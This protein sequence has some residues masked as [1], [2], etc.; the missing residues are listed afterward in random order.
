MGVKLPGFLSIKRYQDSI[1]R[2]AN[3]DNVVSHVIWFDLVTIFVLIL[4]KASRW[5]L[6]S[7]NSLWVDTPSFLALL[8]LD[9]TLA[10][11]WPYFCDLPQ[12]RKKTGVPNSKALGPQV[13]LPRAFMHQTNKNIWYRLNC[14]IIIHTPLVHHVI[15][16]HWNG[17]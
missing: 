11:S 4:R 8:G 9:Q 17:K 1:I 15:T 3:V 14:V 12:F 5:K 6:F 13:P 7:S 10:T 16:S 2:F